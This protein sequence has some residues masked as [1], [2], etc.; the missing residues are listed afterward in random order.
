M[1]DERQIEAAAQAMMAFMFAPHEL[2]LSD[3]LQQKYRE[4][5]AV[6]LRAAEPMRLANVLRRKN[7]V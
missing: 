3:E 4:C 6:A 7:G 5:A 1:I 2:P